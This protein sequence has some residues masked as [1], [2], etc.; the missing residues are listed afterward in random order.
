MSLTLKLK[1][2]VN[3]ILEITRW[4]VYM[5][6]KKVVKKIFG[7]VKVKNRKK[8]T[9]PESEEVF[10]A[11]GVPV[12]K[13]QVVTTLAEAGAAAEKLGFPIVLKIVSP[14]ILH[15]TDAK[16]IETNLKNVKELKMGF[17]KLMENAKKFNP[18]ARIH[19]MLVQRMTPPGREVIVGMTN[20]PLFGP[21]LMFGLGGVLVEVMKDVSFRIAPITRQDALEMI[22]EI[23]GYPIL[24]GA[25][26]ES[27][28]D[29]GSLA[30]ILLN[31]SK[32]AVEWPEIAEFDLNPIFAYRKGALA[33]DAMMT[34]A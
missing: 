16:C 28:V 1:L 32:L 8:L 13:G 17:V 34:L 26:G 33:V 14:D 29:I 4:V 18:D 19:G 9:E 5:A 11:Y 27:P 30:K 6:N 24:K 20:D 31:A 3:Q 21:M 7:Q 12:V 22:H 15:K 23:R 10:K 25:R 2:D